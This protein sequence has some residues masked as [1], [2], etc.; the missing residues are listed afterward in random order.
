MINNI[1]VYLPLIY[2]LHNRH[3]INV[4]LEK[5]YK[6]YTKNNLIKNNYFYNNKSKSIKD[7]FIK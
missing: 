2:V 1:F 4:Y 6:V 7:I 5:I 3:S